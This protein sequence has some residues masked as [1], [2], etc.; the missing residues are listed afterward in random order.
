MRGG[1]LP[2]RTMGVAEAARVDFMRVMG[3]G[4]ETMHGN[5]PKTLY[6]CCI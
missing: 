5:C 3:G 2:L 4:A 1:S 6:C